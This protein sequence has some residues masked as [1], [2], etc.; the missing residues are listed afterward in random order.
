[1]MLVSDPYRGSRLT[2]REKFEKEA[3]RMNLDTYAFWYN[4]LFETCISGIEW[5]RLP[6]EIDQRYLEWIL[7]VDGCALFFYDEEMRRFVVTQFTSGGRFNIYKNPKKR[8]PITPNGERYNKVL[9][10]ND[11][12]IIW[13][14]Y[15]HTPELL[16]LRLYA[17]RLGELDRAIDVNIKGQKTPK[18]I[19]C[20]KESQMTL[21][22]LF[23][24]YDGN[25][26]FIFGNKGL[27]KIAE[28]NVMDCSTPFIASELSIMKRQ[29]FA[30]AMTYYGVENANTE[31]R[32]RLVSDEVISNLGAVESAQNTRLAAREDAAVL[33]NQNAYFKQFADLDIRPVY[34][35]GNITERRIIENV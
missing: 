20:D 28:I 10:E 35:G 17:S 26:P 21:E 22:N 31:K 13:N 14:N 32:E 8:R 27:N 11:S 5:R 30:E 1:M 23:N 34:R 24:K 9:T 4:R 29:L 12:V 33:I 2:I 25:I 15:T 6:L 3:E 19:M 7:A 16:S 18:I